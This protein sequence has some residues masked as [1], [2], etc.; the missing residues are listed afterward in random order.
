MDTIYKT[1]DGLSPVTVDM[2][3]RHPGVEGWTGHLNPDKLHICNYG[4]YYVTGSQMLD[5][6]ADTIYEA[7]PCKDHEPLS[8]GSTSVTCRLRL[9]RRFDGWTPRSAVLFAADC[10]EHV[11]PLFEARFPDDSRPR[12]AIVAARRFVDG[13]ITI[14]DL[15]AAMYAA[16]AARYA[17]RYAVWAA[18][19]P[20]DCAARAATQVAAIAAKTTAKAAGDVMSAARAATW[21]ARYAREARGIGAD[22]AAE[23]EWQYQCFVEYLQQQT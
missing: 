23:K 16:R 22:E 1:F 4:Y 19:S 21:A 8:S 2:T 20:A 11:L 5:W 9:V 10:A 15:E 12:D 7:E 13:E 3:Y 6:L 14:D 18:A 17:A